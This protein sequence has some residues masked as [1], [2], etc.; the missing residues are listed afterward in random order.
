MTQ[1]ALIV[2]ALATDDEAAD[3]D[4]RSLPGYDLCIAVDAGTRWFMQRDQVPDLAVGDFDS[5][6]D[7][8]LL[9]LE[10][11]KVPT[12]RV[13]ADKDF[14]DLELALRQCELRRIPSAKIIGALGGRIDH[15]LCV[16][17]ALQKSTIPCLELEGNKQ[18]IIRLRAEG[19]V[20]N[21]TILRKEEARS[22]TFSVIALEASELSIK[23]ACWDLEY[24]E[25]SALSS[26][27]LSN[28][29]LDG[30]IRISLHSGC[31]L[32]IL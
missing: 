21:S 29:F 12:Q 16:L 7:E 24:K 23:G 18:R 11:E 8:A 1:K 2:C 31:V 28:E 6:S 19:D 25:V 4:S 14:S 30:D 9:W 13:N 3:E 20:K 27:G 26:L 5:I 10:G 22:K 32:V 17:G 15:Q